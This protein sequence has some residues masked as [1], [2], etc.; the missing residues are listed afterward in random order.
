MIPPSIKLLCLAVLLVNFQSCASK[1]EMVEPSLVVNPAEIHIDKE[2]GG[3]TVEIESSLAWTISAN[4]DWVSL[5]RTGAPSSSTV[6]V[7]AAANPTD[8][9]RSAFVSVKSESLTEQILVTQAAGDSNSGTGGEKPLF[10]PPDDTD[11]RPL[12]CIELTAEM[13]TG[14]NIGNTLDAIG[15]ETAWGNPVI[16]Q[17]LIDS[18]Q[19][20]GFDAIRLPVAW[21]KFSD[22]ATFKIQKSWLE[23]VEQVVNYILINDMY[24][25]INIHWD[26]GWIQP[27]YE[28]E[29]YVNQ[30]LNAMWQ[31]IAIHFRD[32]NDHLLF[33]G[34]NEILVD[35]E[36]GT[37][38]EENYTVQNGYNQTFVSTVR[39]TGGRNHY[40]HLVVQ[41]YNT[42]ISH[43]LNFFELPE[44][45]VEN[46]L[47]LEVHYYD[48]YNF[49]LNE[50]TNMTQWGEIATNPALA[51]AWANEAY[52]DN[53][54]KQLK[55]QFYDNGVAII[56]GEYGVISREEVADF[57]TYREYYLDYLTEAAYDNNIVPFYWDNGY[58]GN[59]SMA[60]FN[61][62][63]GE[64]AYP[65][66]VRAI[67]IE[68]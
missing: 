56:L 2:G 32:Y 44:D 38:T 53:Q 60:L 25:I 39:A 49:T 3:V 23:R 14:W 48:P 57:E 51:E 33:A 58:L 52:L 5:S 8:Q 10:I 18:I 27:L 24:A 17:L 42:N 6:Q 35:G 45:V 31:Q 1:E 41:G 15:G 28:D 55:S 68:E 54:F 59:H 20:A 64:Q 7:G 22:P 13:H 47:T 36:Y 26:G 4:E 62:N 21:S 16:T 67:V 30:R 29:E 66:L 43:T 12:T 40:R 9:Q 46:R 61:R 37:P 50:N 34:T 63:T 65:D 11:M 19:A